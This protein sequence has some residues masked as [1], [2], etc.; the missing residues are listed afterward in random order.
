MNRQPISRTALI[1]LGAVLLAISYGS[2]ALAQTATP[3]PSDYATDV[4]NGQIALRTDPAVA[5][6]AKEVNDSEKHEGDVDNETAEVKEAVEPQEAAEA[7]E[8]A[9]SEIRSEPSSNSG[10][11]GQR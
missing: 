10:A 3:K 4:Q 9:E 2:V 5:A 8:P 11:G 7:A 1:L 6:N